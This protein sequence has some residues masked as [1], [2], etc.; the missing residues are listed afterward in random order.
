MLNEILKA[1]IELEEINN[2][3]I[4]KQDELI[5]Q[6]QEQNQFLRNLVD[7]YII[8]EPKL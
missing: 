5:K 7:T 2:G 8:K 6:L 4:A 3:I 1:H